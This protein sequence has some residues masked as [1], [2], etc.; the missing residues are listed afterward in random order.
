MATE[1]PEIPWRSLRALVVDDSQ[2]AS[3]ILSGQLADL[4][5]EVDVADSAENALA[6]LE[7]GLPDIVFMDHL[8]PGIDGLEA[9]RFLRG[10]LQTA[11][12]PICMYTSQDCEGFVDRARD[13][14]ANDVY[15]KTCEE[16]RLAVILRRL[17]LLPK[18][19]D[20]QTAG[21]GVTAIHPP[22]RPATAPE[23]EVSNRG[24]F[25]DGANLA[26]LLEPSLESHHEKLR[27]ELLAEFAILERYEERMRHDLFSRV[28]SLMGI[29]TE[30]LK[31]AFAEY[32]EAHRAQ[33][34][35]G[36]LRGL[37]LAAVV[38]A[39]FGLSFAM[40]WKMSSK[41]EQSI[42][43]QQSA[44]RILEANTEAQSALRRE[45]AEARAIAARP[46]LAVTESTPPQAGGRF[47]FDTERE[48]G[49]AAALV[50]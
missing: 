7:R 48:S 10:R 1:A 13:A 11:S 45:L 50:N 27:K 5:F 16:S 32:R 40:N 49:V 30:Q 6:R 25:T 42:A 34:W 28:E 19:L 24:M 41:L 15:T 12:L 44:L 8:L 26:T 20:E 17:N 14:G 33:R 21:V 22:D 46:Y 4:G 38:L 9:V 47:S 23:S 31:Q 39:C 2:I 43:E 29:T 37:A 18:A 3:Y 35:V 36:H